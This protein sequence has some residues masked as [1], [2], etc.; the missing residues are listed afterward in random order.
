M[1]I[2]SNDS[3]LP[4]PEYG[5][6]LTGP[7]ASAAA[8]GEAAQMNPPPPAHCLVSSSE[9]S[10]EEDMQAQNFPLPDRMQGDAMLRGAPLR[11]TKAKAPVHKTT[12]QGLPPAGPWQITGLQERTAQA[13]THPE[14]GPMDAMAAAGIETLAPWEL[15][16]CECSPQ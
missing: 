13:G 8:E 5:I 3:G 9:G 14:D 11:I 2:V 10:S 4:L 1:Q 16:L 7:A 15:H 12:A 6:Y